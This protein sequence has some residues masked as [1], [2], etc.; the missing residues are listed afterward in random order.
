MG[1]L[2][3]KIDFTGVIIV[4]NANPNGDPINGNR[5][6]QDFDGT[7]IISDVCLKRKIRDRLQDHGELIFVQS[8]AKCID[9]YKSLRERAFADSTIRKL[10]SAGRS[11]EDEFIDAACAKWCDVRMF[12]QVFAFRGASSSIGIRGPV[13]ITFATSIDKI[14]I[15]TIQIT[16]S[17]NGYDEGARK[18]H[19]TMGYRHYVRH[20]AY[21]FSGGIHPQL[22]EKTGFTDEDA[23]KL[24]LAIMR[25]FDGDE[26]KA[27]PAGSMELARLYWWR[28][29]S[30][31]G[32]Y[33]PAV[34]QRSVHFE[35]L[36]EWP[37][38]V[39][40]ETHLPGLKPEIYDLAHI[41]DIY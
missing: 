41:G 37:Y 10:A 2:A 22:A 30:R 1:I 21:V 7:G 11:N 4:Q 28:H 12:G 39:A 6:R 13:S 15:D 19:D 17:T 31:S 14:D 35:A 38:F 32:Q 40:N 27:R 23:D 36:D 18:G 33:S 5:P 24:Q 8:D 3:Q 34:V 29:S 26:S 16:K 20:A 25:M 9:G